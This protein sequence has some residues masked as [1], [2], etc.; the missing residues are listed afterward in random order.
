[1]TEPEPFPGWRQWRARSLAYLDEG[2]PSSASGFLE[3][4]PAIDGAFQSAERT[5]TLKFLCPR[6]YLD[7]L[8]EC[9]ELYEELTD[10]LHTVVPG[11]LSDVKLGFE[12]ATP[13]E[14]AA[15]RDDEPP[16]GLPAGG[17]A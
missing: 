1:M 17:S 12:Y 15:F 13:D 11:G 7:E 4:C 10:A 16:P 6:D 2:P 8:S 5:L 9:P 3:D 14:L